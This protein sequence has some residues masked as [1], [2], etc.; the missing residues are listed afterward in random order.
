[1]FE[2]LM[3]LT[4]AVANP[5]GEPNYFVLD[6]NLSAT[7]CAVAMAEWDQGPYNPLITFECEP[8]R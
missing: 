1:M 7:D 4:M 3:V 8:E 2:V 5:A 6:Y